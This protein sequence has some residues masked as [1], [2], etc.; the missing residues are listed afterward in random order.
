MTTNEDIAHAKYL[1]ADAALAQCSWMTMGEADATSLLDDI[2]PAV[3]DRYPE[4]SLSGEMAGD[5]IP[6]IF[7]DFEDPHDS[8]LHDAWE[9]GRD[10]VFQDA[11][12]AVALRTLG[13]I[14]AALRVDQE[15]EAKVNKLREE[16]MRS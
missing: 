8:N 15:N 16:Y 11:R 9:E 3:L 4:P 12:Q 6:E 5:S 1:G 2:D 14:A 7:S 10:L 13:N